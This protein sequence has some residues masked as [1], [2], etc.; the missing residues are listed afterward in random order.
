MTRMTSIPAHMKFSATCAGMTCLALLVSGCSH[1]PHSQV[2]NWGGSGGADASSNS[3]SGGYSAPQQY[4]GAP[5]ARSSVAT[6][7]QGCMGGYSVRDLRTNALLSSGRAF[8]SGRGLIALDGQGRQTQALP[9]SS[10]QS[11]LFLPDCNCRTNG[12]GRTS[13]LLDT[14]QVAAIGVRAPTCTAG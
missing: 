3:Q 13:S 2:P 5:V 9:T 12:G 14:N 4:V 11:I 10:S 8:N 6:F 1:R 7:T